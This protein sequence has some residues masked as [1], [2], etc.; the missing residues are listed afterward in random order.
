VLEELPQAE[1]DA[2]FLRQIFT[3][4]RELQGQWLPSVPQ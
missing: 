2:E 1:F 4:Q 3:A